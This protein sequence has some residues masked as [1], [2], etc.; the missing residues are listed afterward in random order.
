MHTPASTEKPLCW[1]ASISLASKLSIRPRPTKA[2]TMRVRA[3]ACTWATAAGRV[4]VHTRRYGEGGFVIA[5]YRL[6]HP[7]NHADMEMH[8]GVQAGADTV[9][10]SCLTSICPTFI[11]CKGLRKAQG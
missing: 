10:R 2:R 3:A 5:R 6:K 11:F 8:M 1:Q 7:I 4:K 9:G